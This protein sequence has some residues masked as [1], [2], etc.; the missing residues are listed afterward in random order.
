[1]DPNKLN[2][3]LS[4]SNTIEGWFYPADMVSIAIMDEI[5]TKHL[6]ISGSICEVGV[7]KGKSLTFLSHLIRSDELL[8]GY[9][10]FLNDHKDLT[11]SAMNEHGNQITPILKT[12]NTNQ[13]EGDQI[14]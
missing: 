10:D 6:G 4:S 1:M 13:L 8:F 9:D 5:Q 12:C 11:L 3:F 7:Y 2:W 14:S